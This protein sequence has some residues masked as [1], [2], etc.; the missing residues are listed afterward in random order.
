[1]P[2]FAQR[3]QLRAEEL[4]FKCETEAALFATTHERGHKGMR[5]GVWA[6]PYSLVRGGDMYGAGLNGCPGARAAKLSR[7]AISR[8]GW[9]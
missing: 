5:A 7:S 1:M 4:G 2:Q 6:R 8:W 9:R 3:G